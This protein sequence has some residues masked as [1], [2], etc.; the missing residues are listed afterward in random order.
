[1]ERTS[2][3]TYTFDPA[4]NER[5]VEDPAGDL[6]TY[7][8]DYEN[9]MRS[10]EDP[11]GEITTYTYS[12]ALPA[13]GERGVP[14]VLCLDGLGALLKRPGGG[15][16]KPLLR[17]LISRAGVRLI[18]ILSRWEYNDLIG[19]DADMAD[20]FTRIEIEEP[21]E[22]T[23]LAIARHHAARSRRAGIRPADRGPG[24]RADGRPG[25][26]V[27]PQRVPS[28]QVD[29]H[30]AAGLLAK[31]VGCNVRGPTTAMVAGSDYQTGESDPYDSITRCI[32]GI[33]RR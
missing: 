12:A 4:G 18:G 27:H 7:T 25:V 26:D 15:T 32:P 1:V 24:R 21:S 10:A 3:T 2:R 31:L 6:T 5:S 9:Q 17:A 30:P 20:L 33:D 16:N 14:L 11:A 13:S 8:W 29:P 23:A 19:G 28:G 22:Q